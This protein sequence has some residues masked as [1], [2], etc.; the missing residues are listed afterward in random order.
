MF[1][2]CD[3]EFRLRG[4]ERFLSGNE[5]PSLTT[6]PRK[7]GNVPKFDDIELLHHL[8]LERSCNVYGRRKMITD[9]RLPDNLK[10]ESPQF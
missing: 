8:L 7:P 5:N 10:V 2:A 6:S 9:R 3:D 1:L 4:L